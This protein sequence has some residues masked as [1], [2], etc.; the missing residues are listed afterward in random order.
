MKEF[1]P[2]EKIPIEPIVDD[3]SISINANHN[4]ESYEMVLHPRYDRIDFWPGRNFYMLKVIT[5]NGVAAMAITQEEVDKI[6]EHI[7][8]PMCYRDE[9]LRSEYEFYLAWETSQLDDNWLE[10]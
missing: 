9:I 8:I 5:Q 1:D 6:Y 4:G 7:N 10:D 2:N 3:Y